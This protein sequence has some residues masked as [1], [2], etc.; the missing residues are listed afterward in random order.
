MKETVGEKFGQAKEK[1]GYGKN[2][3]E[4]NREKCSRNDCSDKQCET[5]VKNSFN[6]LLRIDSV[7]KG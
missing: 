2:E 6:K 7:R 5:H 3:E 1:P 4:C